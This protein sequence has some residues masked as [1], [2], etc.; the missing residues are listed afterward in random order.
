MTRHRFEWTQ[1]CDGGVSEL[2]HGSC[3]VLNLT[4]HRMARRIQYGRSVTTKRSVDWNAT[5]RTRMVRLRPPRMTRQVATRNAV[6]TTDTNNTGVYL[7][8]ETRRGQQAHVC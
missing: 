8:R 6:E 1:P 5:N 4:Y 7:R 2:D 3:T